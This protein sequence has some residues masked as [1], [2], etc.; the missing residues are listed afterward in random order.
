V[1]GEKKSSGWRKTV[2][3]F[4]AHELESFVQHRRS[5]CI[6]ATS[7]TSQRWT[8]NADVA[9]VSRQKSGK[10]AAFRHLSRRKCA[11]ETGQARAL[12]AEGPQTFFQQR[13]CKRP[14][15]IGRRFDVPHMNIRKTAPLRVE[16]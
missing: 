3:P 2:F 8:A 11:T 14:G 7:R 16:P 9:M 4:G 1:I 13:L 5:A 12:P 15:M 10:I 6:P